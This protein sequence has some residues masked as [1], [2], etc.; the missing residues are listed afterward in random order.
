M[1]KLFGTAA[2]ATMLVAGAAVNASMT[3]QFDVNGIAVQTTN[4]AGANSAFGGL[5]HTGAVNFSFAPGITRLVDIAISQNLGAPASQGFSGSLSNFSGQITMNNG[6]V[7]GGQ[8]TLTADGGHTYTADIVGNVGAVSNYVGGGYK[9]QGLTFNGMFSHP[10]FGN[11]DVS[12]WFEAQGL[13]GLFGSFL[14]F[15]FNPDASGA[16]FADMDIFVNAQVIPLP[17]A[18]WTGI[19][20]LSGVMLLGYI[21]RRR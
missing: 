6:Q 10:V 7:T 11:V 12:P 9:I 14:Q 15:N 8:L 4:G 2:V 1:K 19:A 13:G 20:T 21:R 16:S 17:P 3:L 18:A 5:A